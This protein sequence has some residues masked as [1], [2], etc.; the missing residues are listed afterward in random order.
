MIIL[1]KPYVSDFL[2][3]TIKKNNFCVLDNEIARKYF[4]ESELI[5]T[6]EA[7][8]KYKN[9]NELV[10][11][12]SENSIDWVGENLPNSKLDENIKTS[13]DKAKFRTALKKIYPNYFF[14]EVTKNELKE[15]DSNTLPYP[16]I[17]KPSIGF[18]SFGVYP[19]ENEKDIR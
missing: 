7:I 18:L 9:N 15:I 3:E 4:S 2:I 6:Q 17:L 1:A 8:E 19:I 12:N 5:T 14:M 16:I 10:Y 13:K 11:S